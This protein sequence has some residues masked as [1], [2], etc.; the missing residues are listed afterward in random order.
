M[1]NLKYSFFERE[2]VLAEL[3]KNRKI[4][5]R[6]LNL[7]KKKVVQYL[8]ALAFLLFTAKVLPG[9]NFTRVSRV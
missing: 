5:Q 4:F 2:I 6:K 1:F 8:V 7:N 9:M 3:E